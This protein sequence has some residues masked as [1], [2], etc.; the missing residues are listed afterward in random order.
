MSRADDEAWMRLALD[1][2]R[3]AADHGDVPVGAVVVVGDEV[4]ARAHN[5]RE[6][7]V[8]PTAHAEVLAIR[9]AAAATGSWRLGDATLHVTLEPCHMC[10]GALVQARLGRLV[11]AATDPR[12]GAVGSLDDLADDPRLNHRITVRT[13]VLADESAALLTDFFRRR[14]GGT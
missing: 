14:R 8:D 6:V 5:R 10:A 1:E 13:G 4:V 3:S 2:A 7:D 12:A 9:A 11:Q